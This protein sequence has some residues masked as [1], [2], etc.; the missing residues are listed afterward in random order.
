MIDRNKYVDYED[1]RGIMSP[2]IEK[3]LIKYF[4]KTLLNRW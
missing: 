1:D 4:C 2:E 3:S